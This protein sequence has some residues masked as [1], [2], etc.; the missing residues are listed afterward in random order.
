MSEQILEC[1]A[2]KVFISSINS[3]ATITLMPWLR[4]RP[5]TKQLQVNESCHD[6][7]SQT[8]LKVNY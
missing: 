7:I 6:S 1:E 2:Y 5:T 3:D 8:P 4:A